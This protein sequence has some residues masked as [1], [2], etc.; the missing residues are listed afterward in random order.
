MPDA[1]TPG[2]GPPEPAAACKAQPQ[3]LFNSGQRS[4][5]AARHPGR[6]GHRQRAPRLMHNPCVGEARLP[7]AARRAVAGRLQGRAVTR[8]HCQRGLVCAR[9]SLQA[10]TGHQPTL[11]S[12]WQVRQGAWVGSSRCGERHTGMPPAPA[13]PRT[14]RGRALSGPDALRS[15][16]DWRPLAPPPPALFMPGACAVSRRVHR[17]GHDARLQHAP[18][19]KEACSG[20]ADAQHTLEEL[21]ELSLGVLAEWTL[22][23]GASSPS[24]PPLPLVPPPPPPAGPSPATPA[25]SLLG[26]LAGDIGSSAGCP[27]TRPPAAR[28]RPARSAPA[29]GTSP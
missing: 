3:A 16:F 17:L 20:E 23:A 26:E 4:G 9:R 8:A 11:A 22:R 1:R 5:G 27:S 6:H 21:L 12:V 10:H 15:F 7:A 29:P 2:A 14:P 25:S 24:L 28:A 13:A 19:V 18:R